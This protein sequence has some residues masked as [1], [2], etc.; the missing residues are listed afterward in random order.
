MIFSWHWIAII[1]WEC[2]R[3]WGKDQPHWPSILGGCHDRNGF[4]KLNKWPRKMLTWHHDTSI[5][6]LESVCRLVDWTL[7]LV[8]SAKSRGL[9]CIQLGDITPVACP[10]GSTENPLTMLIAFTG[11]GESDMLADSVHLACLLQQIFSSL[12][13]THEGLRWQDFGWSIIRTKLSQPFDVIN[14]EQ[15]STHIQT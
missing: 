14:V 3:V 10:I 15:W 13:Q 12:F 8:S 7:S 11:G 1:F 4:H 9:A 5:L 6:S 2:L